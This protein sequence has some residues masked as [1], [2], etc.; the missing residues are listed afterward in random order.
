MRAEQQRYGDV[1]RHVGGIV[2]MVL[3]Q[4]PEGR[5]TG[6]VLDASRTA[7]FLRR[8]HEYRL[9]EVQPEFDGTGWSLVR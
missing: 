5:F 7:D 9:G 3:V 1:L 6:I 2:V 4:H 8:L